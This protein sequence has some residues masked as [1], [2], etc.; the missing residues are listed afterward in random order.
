[1]AET[2]LV[3]D[4]TLLAV[5]EKRGLRVL[6]HPLAVAFGLGESVSACVLRGR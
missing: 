2:A 1:M 6:T 5:E 3:S 4:A